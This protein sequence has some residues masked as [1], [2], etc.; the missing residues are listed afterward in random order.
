MTD[1]QMSYLRTIVFVSAIFGCYTEFF[2]L[3]DRRSRVTNVF[4]RFSNS[5]F[6]LTEFQLLPLYFYCFHSKV[7]FFPSSFRVLSCDIIIFWFGF[8]NFNLAYRIVEM[9]GRGNSTQL[10]A[11]QFHP[12]LFFILTP[13]PIYKCHSHRLFCSILLKYM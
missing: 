10:Y 12:P 6:E 13:L 5:F 11:G 8:A 2:S 4:L 3:S 7:I 9:I 1:C